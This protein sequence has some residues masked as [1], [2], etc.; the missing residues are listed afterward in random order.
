MIKIVE[1]VK[2]QKKECVFLISLGPTAT[3]LAYD[4]TRLGYQAIDIGHIDVEYEWYLQGAKKKV[5]LKGKYVNE[6]MEKGD[7]SNLNIND[8]KYKKSIIEKIT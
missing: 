5:P 1:A 7:L 8:E 4:L 6:A 2:K 3:I